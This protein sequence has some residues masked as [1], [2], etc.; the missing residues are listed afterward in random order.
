MVDLPRFSDYN[1][2]KEQ[3]EENLPAQRNPFDMEQYKNVQLPET[4]ITYGGGMADT[5][6]NDNEVP[7][8]IRKPFWFIFH[9][10]NTL[11]FLDEERKQNKLLNM[12]IIKIDILNS[13]PYYDYTFDMEMQLNVLRNIYETKLD[14]ALGIKGHNERLALISQFSENKQISEMSTGSGNIKQGFLQR[15]FARR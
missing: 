11:T 5:L 7:D 13:I 6:L 4:P 15:L 3:P 8:K 1:V 2:N 10:D 14:R 9:K 12:D